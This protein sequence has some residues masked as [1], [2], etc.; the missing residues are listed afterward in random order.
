MI[1]FKL[2]LLRMRLRAPIKVARVL[3]GSVYF[4]PNR[5]QM[6]HVNRDVV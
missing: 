4:H 6:K 3:T 1:Q 5:S 2:V